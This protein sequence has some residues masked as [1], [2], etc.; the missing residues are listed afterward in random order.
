M[1]IKVYELKGNNT[2][3]L[4]ESDEI[5]DIKKHRWVDKGESHPMKF[6]KPKSFKNK[7]VYFLHLYG[8]TKKPHLGKHISLTFWENQKFLFMQEK[9]WIQKEENVRYVVNILFLI[10]GLTIG[11]LNFLKK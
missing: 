7:N 8:D 4:I 1:K 6:L 5:I 2:G 9:H 11:I 3:L 10:I